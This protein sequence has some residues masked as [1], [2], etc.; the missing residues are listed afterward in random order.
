M[1]DS[2]N[3]DER[4]IEKV[5]N[6]NIRYCY[7]NGCERLVQYIRPNSRCRKHRMIMEEDEVSI[8]IVSDDS[9]YSTATC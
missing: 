9:Q 3:D 4:K 5:D 2:K 7:V 6:G 8:T 1:L